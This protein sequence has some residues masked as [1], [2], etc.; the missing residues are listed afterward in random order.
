M[1]KP[2]TVDSDDLLTLLQ[3][4]GAIKNLERALRGTSTESPGDYEAAHVRLNKAHTLA[5]RDNA[6]RPDWDEPLLASD[7]GLLVNH[8]SRRDAEHEVPGMRVDLGYI[9]LMATA[10]ELSGPSSAF[11]AL[12]DRGYVIQGEVFDVT[13]WAGDDVPEKVRNPENR[14]VKLTN[15][16][17]ERLSEQVRLINRLAREAYDAVQKKDN[18]DV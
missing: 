10:R 2:V 9:T 16:G 12:L 15:R 14:R 8:W 3:A 6:T 13:Q 1:G 17:K 18:G 11:R 4:T 5:L 7:V